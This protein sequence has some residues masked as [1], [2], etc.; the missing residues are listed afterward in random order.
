MN[1]PRHLARLVFSYLVGIDDT[2]EIAR[3]PEIKLYLLRIASFLP[4]NPLLVPEEF[5]VNKVAD[6]VTANVPGEQA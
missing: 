4:E 5:L 3:L 2:V 6:M 1:P